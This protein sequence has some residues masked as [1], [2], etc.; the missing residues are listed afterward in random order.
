[1]AN[2][3]SHAT[4]FLDIVPGMTTGISTLTAGLSSINQQFQNVTSAIN[5]QVG[6]IN[7]SFITAGVLASQFA[8][9]ATEAFGEYEQGLKIAQAVSN[10]TASDMTKMS[11]AVESFAVKYRTE[12][13]DL[14]EGLQTLG[15]AGLNSVTEQ[16]E[17][18]ESGLQTAKLEGRELNSV[19][20]E[21]I[22]NTALLG[23]DLKSDN[24]GEQTE[25]V[26]D[27][28]VA[29][30]MTAPITTHDISET[31]KYS[32][33]MLAA[34]GGDINSSE[35]K[36]LIED[37]MGAVAAFAQKGV[38][39]SIAGTALRAFFNKPATQDSSVVEGLS[40]IGLSPEYLWEDGGERM[41]PVSQQIALIQSQMDKLNVST[42]DQMQIWS[43]IVGGKMGQQM[44]KLEAGDIRSLK[45][46]IQD[47]QS[48]ADVAQQSMQ[49][50]NMKLKS[51][52]EAGEVAYVKFGE[53]IATVLKPIL[54]ILTPIM[55][56]LSNPIIN[57]AAFIGFVAFISRAINAAINIVR[58][59]KMEF[60]GLLT[61]IKAAWTM[62]RDSYNPQLAQAVAKRDEHRKQRQIQARDAAGEQRNKNIAAMAG[63]FEK[64][65]GE[66]EK[67]NT[68]LSHV[69]TRMD[70]MLESMSSGGSQANVSI[71]E[72]TGSMSNFDAEI[73]TTSNS[74]KSLG[75]S[76]KEA[77]TSI[78]TD[79]EQMRQELIE[80][81][82]VL[83]S[84]Q[85][86][87]LY[88]P[89]Q[90]NMDYFDKTGYRFYDERSH[91]LTNLSEAELFMLFSD[92]YNFAAGSQQFGVKG[93][94][95][96]DNNPLALKSDK[97]SELNITNPLI[98]GQFDYSNYVNAQQPI[99]GTHPLTG[100]QIVF[101]QQQEDGTM[102][103][104]SNVRDKQGYYR[105][106]EDI[107]AEGQF[108]LR[109]D[110]HY[111]TNMKDVEALRFSAT[112]GPTTE[113]QAKELQHRYDAMLMDSPYAPTSMVSKRQ[114]ERG[115]VPF[116]EEEARL[117]NKVDNLR[118][119]LQQLEADDA[120]IKKRDKMR[121]DV[122]AKFK[123]EDDKYQQRLKEFNERGRKA[124]DSSVIKSVG[125][126]KY[127]LA[128]KK[129]EN[130][131]NEMLG[132]NSFI[133]DKEKLKELQKEMYAVKYKKVKGKEVQDGQ[134]WNLAAKNSMLQNY[135]GELSE[136][137]QLQFYDLLLNKHTYLGTGPKGHESRDR[138]KQ[139][140]EDATEQ[141]AQDIEKTKK[142]LIQKKQN[143]LRKLEESEAYKEIE[144]LIENN[145]EVAKI[146]KEI[147]DANQEYLNLFSTRD[148]W[149]EQFPLGKRLS[150]GQ[151]I[152]D[153]E[154]LDYLKYNKQLTVANKNATDRKYDLSFKQKSFLDMTDMEQEQYLFQEELN[155]KVMED[156]NRR[157][158][159]AQMAKAAPEWAASG[160]FGDIGSD[161]EA[162]EQ[163]S[164]GAT[165][166]KNYLRDKVFDLNAE[167]SKK[168]D[169]LKN[170]NTAITDAHIREL[171]EIE[172]KVTEARAE[173]E[174]ALKKD[175][176]KLN[177]EYRQFANVVSGTTP[178][179]AMSAMAGKDISEKSTT[180][181][182]DKIKSFFSRE[183]DEKDGPGFWSALWNY[184]RINPNDSRDAKDR[185]E[186]NNRQ[187]KKAFKG[188]GIVSG[189]KSVGSG[190]QSLGKGMLN[191]VG[192][193]L[194]ALTIG[195]EIA[196]QVFQ[197]F[198]QAYQEKLQKAKQQ[199]EDATNAIDEAETA[200]KSLY[201]DE[202]PDATAAQQNDYILSLYGAMV[203]SENQSAEQTAE[204][205]DILG[206]MKSITKSYKNQVDKV[207][208][209]EDGNY[210]VVKKEEELISAED[211]HSKAVQEN[212][213]ALRTATMELQ[214][215][216][217]KYVAVATDGTFGLDGWYSNASDK[218]GGFASNGDFAKDG[219]TFVLTPSQRGE[220]YQGYT[221]LAGLMLEDIKDARREADTYKKS[222]YTDTDAYAMQ[223]GYATFLGDDSAN[224]LLKAVQN[225]RGGRTAA[226]DTLYQ[227]AA[228]INRLSAAQNARAQQSMKINKKDWQR[229]GKEIAKYEKATGK[230]A[231]QG[232]TGNKRIE[233]LIKKLGIDTRLDRAN[234]VR[235]AQLQQL[236]DMYQVAES[237]FVP[238]MNQI[239]A[240]TMA[241]YNIAGVTSQATGDAASGAISTANN[242]AAIAAYLSV[243]AL[244]SA[245][246][247]S[248]D[249]AVLDG[250]FSGTKE[251]WM[252]KAGSKGW[253]SDVGDWWGATSAK[254]TGG[255]YIANKEAAD[256]IFTDYYAPI[257]AQN[258]PDWSSDQ[259]ADY[260]KKKAKET[261]GKDFMSRFGT[262]SRWYQSTF[263]P[264]IEDAYLASD[265]GE[266][267]GSGSGSGSGGGGDGG[268]SDS[269][270]KNTKNRVDLVLCNKKEIPKL[271]VNL[272]KKEPSFTVLNKNFKVRDIKVN[273]QDKPK[274][275]LSSVKNAII[276]V[277]KRTDPKI[278]QDEEGEYD[279]VAATE[280]NS[281]PSGKT[282][283][284]IDS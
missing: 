239:M 17:V 106:I 198:Q 240:T 166:Y 156:H 49:T 13:N 232:D 110:S 223:K 72:V 46:D 62:P 57:E 192:G 90:M 271:N 167:Y 269:D 43:K 54:D 118:A 278:I 14:T 178:G 132:E 259:V 247:Y 79:L 124:P 248:Y 252:A 140:I 162:P 249:K 280:G 70:T 42:M 263:A 274:A 264:A 117:Q 172:R 181:L 76:F 238:Q 125:S 196:T 129:L 211:E 32:G 4:V 254:L 267:T 224:K 155:R 237:T 10:Q 93:P 168:L 241:H 171:E 16:T 68:Q 144:A 131:I 94:L 99:I 281:T 272:F 197:A 12:L 169:Q 107:N 157:V 185:K 87:R 212:S 276:D 98:S 74:S 235:L 187:L 262:A 277:E 136:G 161:Y 145:P 177:Q 227:Q 26:N 1:M 208:Q 47:A 270:N 36:E 159:E 188:S 11:E 120:N 174:A 113:D 279:P 102:L 219:G 92:K 20:E 207:E 48:A 25:Y 283:T 217:D 61:E 245:I 138:L 147:D 200:L 210:E 15:R 55:E 41:K 265:V 268:G 78:K 273:T 173:L 191:F 158:I 2:A 128:G 225:P 53:H 75:T 126:G 7:T 60:A 96:L 203:T 64:I 23:G 83:E 199:L 100:G 130:I 179:D 29:T 101:L 163:I 22:Q 146:K 186:R 141:E 143:A 255:S 151:E 134:K 260:A 52:A 170:S 30:S 195:V 256:M 86:L 6:L 3:E 59:L 104:L 108:K 261:S 190:L 81:K 135:I 275:I 149:D 65:G 204:Q 71:K 139:A 250:G 220:D 45:K 127:G 244:E 164:L 77:A 39:G 35:G 121:D 209:T 91:S 153:E 73:K 206:N 97:K 34:A 95:E 205:N 50:F 194:A 85:N 27:V 214:V 33:G 89:G 111:R 231:L 193:P 234:V 202:N 82:S 63:S 40:A 218:M 251:E 58:R 9:K 18:L 242:A 258:H 21:L 114:K 51:A 230:H 109:G 24:F 154:S 69:Q 119:E 282:S 137:E 88:S 8:W 116:T 180:S 184:S 142:A 246:Q 226:G 176:A 5:S 182:K 152:P 44:M 183:K 150:K 105:A 236:Q 216:M 67:V 175:T 31:L 284:K 38:S 243:M 233:N 66:L 222:G 229:L 123:E 122:V 257:I 56:M 37:Y 19:L 160:L 133:Q 103:P 266:D 165:Q 221:E 112:K 213:E 28:L 189:I 80:Y 148:S 253:A 115:E 201:K 228:N 215:A 84:T